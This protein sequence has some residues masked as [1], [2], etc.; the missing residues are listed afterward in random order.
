MDFV[1]GNG[2]GGNGGGELGTGGME[3]GMGY[4]YLHGNAPEA[5]EDGSWNNM[6]IR[7]K[8][9]DG[10]SGWGEGDLSMPTVLA[11][12]NLSL[13]RYENGRRYQSYRDGA[14]TLPN[15]EKEQERL[16]FNHHIWL[17]ILDGELFVAPLTSPRRVLDIGTGTGIWAIDFSD[18]YPEAEV[19]GNDLS[20]VK[21]P[22]VPPNCTFHIDDAESDEWTY[23]MEYFDF[24]HFRNLNGAFR[25]WRHVLK[26]AWEHLEPGGYVEMQEFIYDIFW[27][28]QVST[29]PHR[30]TSDFK[31]WC[32]MAR[33]AGIIA[34]RPFH[35]PSTLLAF[36]EENGFVDCEVQNFAWPWGTWCRDK[37]LK[38]IGRY[39]AL[40]MRET[41]HAYTALFTQ[42]LGY[43]QTMVEN[44]ANKAAIDMGRKNSRYYSR[45]FSVF[46]RKPYRNETPKSAAT[47]GTANSSYSASTNT[48]T[49]SLTSL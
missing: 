45:V 41:L 47:S 48:H 40:G 34:D 23:E 21:P 42:A 39:T 36:M 2:T 35:H 14:Y 24:I 38:E 28:G 10:D 15:D 26:Q 7:M 27:G 19:M 16:D 5:E 11:S 9:V 31:S 1:A 22:W 20:P 29:E 25:D 17:L 33:S 4:D 49:S 12:T 37:R 13:Y 18:K 46:G 3:S 8:D 30:S 43:D 44:F 6:S 32:D